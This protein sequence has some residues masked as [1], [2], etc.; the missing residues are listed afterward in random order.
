MVQ[1]QKVTPLV[2]VMAGTPVDTQMG[3][4]LV[5]EKG[6]NTLSLALSNN[7]AEQTTFQTM[8]DRER[9]ATVKAHIQQAQQQNAHA[10]FVYCNSLSGSVDFDNLSQELH[11]PIMTPLHAYQKIATDYHKLGIISANAQGLAGIERV[12]HQ[13]NP[14]LRLWSLAMLPLVEAVECQKT[15][16]QIATQFG[17]DHL[18]AFFEH[19]RVEAI[20]MGCTHFPYIVNELKKRTSLPIIDP[21][22]YM[23]ATLSSVIRDTTSS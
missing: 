1:S 16:H 4:T 15:P 17:F 13:H 23:L 14:S 6:Y 22:R 10:L 2:A 20:V 3:V 18:V 9:Y 7:P 19:N 11:F 8:D 12:L 5:E 21:A